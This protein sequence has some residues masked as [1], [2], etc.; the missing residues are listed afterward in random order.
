MSTVGDPRECLY[1]GAKIPDG[2]VQI[3][4][5]LDDG[6]MKR[7]LHFGAFGCF[8]SFLFEEGILGAWELGTGPA[9]VE[10][11]RGAARADEPA[12]LESPAAMQRRL[13]HA[14]DRYRDRQR[15]GGS[16]D[17]PDTLLSPQED[18]MANA[19]LRVVKGGAR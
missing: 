17:G 8:F 12:G 14:R 11:A 4:M 1:C 9:S 2:V 18:A 15:G 3:S 6:R 16:P 19:I 5:V 13:Q 10:G 7:E